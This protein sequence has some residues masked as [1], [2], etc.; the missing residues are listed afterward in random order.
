MRMNNEAFHLGDHAT[1]EDEKTEEE[2][3]AE[4]EQEQKD[5]EEEEK[6]REEEAKQENPPPRDRVNEL[7][8]RRNEKNFKNKL[9][10]D[11][12]FLTKLLRLI[13]VFTAIS[14][15]NKELH[16][17]VLKVTKPIE[18]SFLLKLLLVSQYNHGI[19]ILKILTNL[20]KIE[21]KSELFNE[22]ITN[23]EN[24]E[25]VQNILNLTPK[26]QIEDC[27]FIQFCFNLLL[28]I[29]SNQWDKRNFESVGSYD[30]SCGIV[31]LFQAILKSN[32]QPDWKEK[33]EKCMDNLLENIETY[34]IEEFDIL[35]SLFEGGEYQGINVGG[36][37]MTKDKNK[38]TTVGFVKRWYGLTPP[39][40]PNQNNDFQ[41]LDVSTNLTN[42]DDYLLAIYYDEKHPERNDMFLTI[43]EEVN[44]IPDLEGKSHDY[45]LNKDRLH[46][47]LDAMGIDQ[48]PNKND[49]VA[50]TKR[51][52]GMKIIV[53][54]IENNGENFSKLLD[55]S[56][57]SKF[58]QFL[59][60]ECSL[61]EQQKDNMKCE[62]YDQRIFAMKKYATE[63]QVSLQKIKETTICFKGKYLGIT[64]ALSTSSK[65]QYTECLPLLSAMNYGQIVQKMH[66]KI[67]DFENLKTS[68]Y[69]NDN[70]S[71]IDSS[72]L[73]S[74]DK[75]VE[76]FKHID[77]I[78]TSDLDI[79]SLH[80]ELIEA[81]K[82][83]AF[84]KSI[85]V[86]SKT[87]FDHI[88]E[89][90][91]DDPKFKRGSTDDMDAHE[92]FL[93]ELET[94]CNFDRS[95]LDN[96][97]KGKEGESLSRKVSLL[98]EWTKNK[99][100]EEKKEEQKEE[101][102]EEVKQEQPEVT[103]EII[104]DHKQDEGKFTK[105]LISILDIQYEENWD[106]MDSNPL[107]IFGL[108]NNNN[109]TSNIN[110]LTNYAN[111]NYSSSSH[112]N[113]TKK[114]EL[115]QKVY[116]IKENTIY[117]DYILTLSSFYKQL[118]RKTLSTFFKELPLEQILECILIDRENFEKFMHYLQIKANEAITVKQKT[119]NSVLYDNFMSLL[120]KTIKICLKNDNLRSFI[121][122]LYHKVIL[123][124]TKDILML[125]N[126][127]KK[128][129]IDLMFDNEIAATKTMN[130]HIVIEILKIL[131]KN[132]PDL[133]YGNNKRFINL[134]TILL[135][136]PVV[137][138]KDVDF[139]KTVYL[140]IHKMILP[141][142]KE[143]KKYSRELKEDL[144]TMKLFK[145]MIEKCNFDVT[146]SSGNCLTNE[147]KIL[148][149]L[150][151]CLRKIDISMT[152]FSSIYSYT[153]TVLEIERS[154]KILKEMKKFDFISY[155]IYY[156]KE[157][158]E[159]QRNSKII[160]QTTHNIFEGKV[161]CKLE[162][163][164]FKKMHVKIDNE[165]KINPLD[166]IAVTT[167]PE[168][169]NLL[170]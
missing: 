132:E 77:V 139:H 148:F 23:I 22:S 98:A 154:I 112:A 45:L 48:M 1:F 163:E 101:V 49:P 95:K 75:I 8:T 160:E 157:L 99:G 170:K 128:G 35:M 78:I 130:T 19:I 36:Y 118:C 60:D 103:E 30:I 38:F 71:I 26:T 169:A 34:S 86:L 150:L 47:F 115:C 119:N 164:G 69:R 158:S 3:K 2:I 73:D 141:I 124:G 82:E 29:R 67:L 37:G 31:R 41:I 121:D 63:R 76:I 153:D 9:M 72:E 39:D 107:E 138:R 50:L 109:I 10:Y 42:K 90:V 147:Q 56:F 110:E 142:M 105:I 40:D 102:K 92:T 12:K 140:L 144:L 89:L 161:S 149:E 61:P 136:L 159:E 131:L 113:V 79:K 17:F 20:I 114:G 5:I 25:I 165:S 104:G 129:K 54:Q 117:G 51:C 43:P 32:I 65:E 143:P 100:N 83:V 168:G 57:K 13:E 81:N 55:D 59:L 166:S 24:L 33:L 152:D 162:Y 135:L 4:Q 68:K 46:N 74:P 14:L 145:K 96:L 28:Y 126:S 106:N 70:I 116:T 85:V 134:I 27:S 62:W 18:I 133:I 91:N 122:I 93:T 53:N 15:K 94:F 151:L 16:Q 52:I 44:L 64:K 120:E 108:E 125:A 87:N 6:K 146:V 137:F 97:F 80:K 111:N 123:K 167:D 58:I 84:F 155:L 88:K 127:K 156:K 11:E 7:L 66:F 21:F